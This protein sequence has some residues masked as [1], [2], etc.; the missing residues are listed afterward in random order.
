MVET[1]AME[2][3]VMVT[4]ALGVETG[5]LV[6]VDTGVEDIPQV[7]TE[8]IGKYTKLRSFCLVCLKLNA[9]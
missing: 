7:A 4:E 2:T 1:G 3:E 8:R 9:F 5:V 6:A